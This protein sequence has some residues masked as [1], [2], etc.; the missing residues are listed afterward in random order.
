MKNIARNTLAYV[1][2]VTLSQYVGS[3]KV[4]I[5]H[6]HNKGGKP[7]FDF[8][9][10]CFTGDFATANTLL[11]RKIWLFEAEFNNDTIKDGTFK[12][13]S[14]QGILSPA[15]KSDS[16]EN[17]SSVRYSFS[18]PYTY[19]TSLDTFEHAY[20]GL[21]TEHEE[22]PDNYLAYFSLSTL[23]RSLFLNTALVIDWELQVTNDSTNY[24][25]VEAVK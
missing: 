20:I 16:T 17:A 12:D 13:H 22:N 23:N 15:R 11:P 24:E 9:A 19:I 14:T 7:L 5:G 1:G 8:L 25:E 3:K 10:S 18:I 21:Y 4:K 6:V 2:D